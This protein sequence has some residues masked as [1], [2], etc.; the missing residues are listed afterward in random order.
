MI[1][2][3]LSCA[4]LLFQDSLDFKPTKE[5]T[6]DQFAGAV[7]AIKARIDAHGDKDVDVKTVDEG[8]KPA[9]I[10]ITA[11]GGITDKM[12]TRLIDFA[13]RPCQIS[14]RLSRTLTK[15]EE[16]Q[17]EYPKAPKGAE[18]IESSP[19]RRIA[20]RMLARPELV[21]N[22]GDI[23]FSKGEEVVPNTNVQ[24]NR[25]RWIVSKSAG[26]KLQKLS[27]DL[28]KEWLILLIDGKVM[29]WFEVAT[30]IESAD[31]KAMTLFSAM[32]NEDDLTLFLMM[33]KNPLPC[34]FAPEKKP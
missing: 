22:S 28:K 33:L 7:K 20:S 24:E 32:N 29:A 34:E 14:W 15:A 23:T 31:P 21:L 17:Y 16:E 19:M 25:F 5:A 1:A 26:N 2:I 6:P 10:Q 8:G 3:V 4:P 27:E 13:T 18:W 30:V 11:K 9:K 12:K